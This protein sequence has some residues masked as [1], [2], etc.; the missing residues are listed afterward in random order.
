MTQ[1][2]ELWAEHPT[3]AN[4]RLARAIAR[5]FITSPNPHARNEA[6][7]ALG[8]LGTRADL[9]AIIGLQNDPWDVVRASVASSLASLGGR[10]MLAR[11]KAIAEDQSPLVRRYAYVAAHDSGGDDAIPWLRQQ[12][13]IE[14]HDWAFIGIELVLADQA[15]E[16]AVYRLFKYASLPHSGLCYVAAST[17]KELGLEPPP[18]PLQPHIDARQRDLKAEEWAGSGCDEDLVS[19]FEV[20]VDNVILPEGI[21]A[22]DSRERREL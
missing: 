5:I 12:R 3:P 8:E 15:D 4:R 7:E 14:E 11:I 13:L 9:H 22:L 6:V 1:A 19:I 17:L 18:N 16:L 10:S 20:R 2:W 21:R